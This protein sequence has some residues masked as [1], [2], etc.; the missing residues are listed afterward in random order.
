M[1]QCWTWRH[2]TVPRNNSEVASS[3]CK[4]CA[5]KGVALKE[6]S[7]LITF[8]FGYLVLTSSPLRLQKLTL[9]ECTY[10]SSFRKFA[11][12]MAK[13]CAERRDRTRRLWLLVSCRNL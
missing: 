12:V 7:Q 13:V 10:S 1:Y 6:E 11:N 8:G 2:G 3:I 4:E 5:P 9:P